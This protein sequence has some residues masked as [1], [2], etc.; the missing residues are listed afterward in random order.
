MANLTN[1]K[2]GVD[3]PNNLPPLGRWFLWADN[4]AAVSRLVKILA[5][6]CVVLFLLDFVANRYGHFSI[7]EIYGFYG[8]AGFV[9]FTVIVISAKLL[10]VLIG[11]DESYYSPRAVDGESYPEDDLDRLSHADAAKTN[12]GAE[13]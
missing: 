2:P 3:D 8:V 6:L 13:S 7:E 1:D 5:G 10:R 4:P 9:A 12:T 11:R